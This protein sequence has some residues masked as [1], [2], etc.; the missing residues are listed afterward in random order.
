MPDT[1]GQHHVE[2]HEVGLHGVEDVERLG[3]VAGDLHAEALALEAD[4]EGLDEGVLVL[5]DQDRWRW[6]VVIGISLPRR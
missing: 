5:D 2:Q 1:F 3:A 4:R 6:G